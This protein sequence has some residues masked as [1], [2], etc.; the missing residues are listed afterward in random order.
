MAKSKQ[1]KPKESEVKKSQ[2]VVV[3]KYEPVKS[4]LRGFY[5]ILLIMGFSLVGYL[6]LQVFGA[7][8]KGMDQ[9][10]TEQRR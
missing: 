1:E 7:V 4:M 10:K 2:K 8:Q 3:K 9:Q 6:G 5:W